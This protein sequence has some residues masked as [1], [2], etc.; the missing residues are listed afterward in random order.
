M[1]DVDY[2][3]ACLAHRTQQRKQSPRLA[4]GQFVGGFVHDQ[5]FNPK[6]QHL[7]DLDELLLGN[8]QA[9]DVEIWID[10][11]TDIMQGLTSTHLHPRAIQPAHRMRGLFMAQEKVL[12]HG[13][14]G[15]ET[16]ALIHGAHPEAP[17]G[18]RGE[19]VR[20]GSPD[21]DLPRRRRVNS[22]DDLDEG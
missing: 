11:E 13:K 10:V 18:G 9:F 14:R 16:Q 15:H 21:V 5:D 6:E 17:G 3:L 12:G 20:Q 2:P 1:R 7:G 22:R 8:A 4:C 19:A